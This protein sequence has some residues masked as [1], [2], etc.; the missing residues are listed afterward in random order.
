MNLPAMKTMNRKH[1]SGAALVI[2]LILLVAL[3][4]MAI[5]SMNSASLDLI[6]AGNEQ[7]RSRAFVA[8]ETGVERAIAGGTFNSGA[9]SSQAA[10]STGSGTDQYDYAITRP[11][12]G[13]VEAAPPGNSEGTFGS[14]YF[15][16]ASTGTS[17]RGTRATSTQEIYEV[18]KTANEFT[19]NPAVGGCT[20]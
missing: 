11:N 10:T 17:V 2:A 9:D 1:Q 3:S 15:R 7:Y 20:L 14:I 6:M 5:S 16:I 4:L 19:C 18:V 12:A 13:I 8:A